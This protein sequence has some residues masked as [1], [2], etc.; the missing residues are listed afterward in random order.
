M[1]TEDEIWKDILSLEPDSYDNYEVFLSD[2]RVYERELA[3]ALLLKWGM[4]FGG[5]IMQVGDKIL[6]GNRVSAIDG[7]FQTY[8]G[9]ALDFSVCYKLTRGGTSL[10][11][12]KVFDMRMAYLSSQTDEVIE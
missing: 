10:P 3:N 9:T 2:R 1:R 6:V 4:Y 8:F 12:D 5:D 7:A 11:Y